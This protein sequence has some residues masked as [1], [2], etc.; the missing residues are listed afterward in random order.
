VKVADLGMVK[1]H[2]EDMSLTQTGHAVGTPWYMPLE[3]AKNAK[4]IDGRS[5]IYALGCTLY[6]LLVGHPPFT[7]R[8]L[9]EVIQAKDQGT[10]PPARQF[11]DEVPERLDLIIAKMVAKQPKYRYQSCEDVIHDLESLQLAADKLDFVNNRSA[12]RSSAVASSVSTGDRTLLTTDTDPN[13]WY[14]LFKEADGAPVTRKYTT[15]QLEKMLQEGTVSASDRVGRTAQGSFRALATYREFQGTALAQATKKGADQNS[16]RYRNLY[17]QIEEKERR[18]ED[19]VERKEEEA[20][21]LA[22]NAYWLNIALALGGALLGVLLLG[23][24][25]WWLATG[26]GG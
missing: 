20:Q 23:F 8:T 26:L 4:E 9:V 21:S 1:T 18:R 24:L 17:K 2:D 25:L 12:V 6:C 22:L 13:S 3:Q 5:D 10:F 11:N 19:R 15:A 16:S 7:G 14:L